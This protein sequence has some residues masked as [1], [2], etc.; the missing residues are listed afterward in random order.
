MPE[1]PSL[2]CFGWV[3]RAD[4]S[5]A[6]DCRLLGRKVT[7]GVRL[8]RR[9]GH[10]C[11]AGESAS[12]VSLML[13]VHYSQVSDWRYSPIAIPL[14]ARQSPTE[15]FLFLYI[16]NQY[17][18]IFWL[19]MRRIVVSIAILPAL[20]ILEMRFYDGNQS[21]AKLDHDDHVV[22]RIITQEASK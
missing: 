19:S 15:I 4:Q 18:R 3:S 16:V 21:T 12:Y 7:G 17:E 11:L 20:T 10:W 1:S 8:R 5:R 14:K 22:N 13:A 2:G 6:W 9:E